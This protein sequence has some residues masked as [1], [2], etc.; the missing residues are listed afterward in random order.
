[1]DRSCKRQAKAAARFIRRSMDGEQ[2]QI[3][4]A[5]KRREVDSPAFFVL[6]GYRLP[7]R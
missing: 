3:V 2:E 4:I 6:P 7:S 5:L 1:M